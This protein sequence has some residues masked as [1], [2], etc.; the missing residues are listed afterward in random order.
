MSPVRRIVQ[1][2]DLMDRREDIR[3]E[4]HVFCRAIYTLNTYIWAKRFRHQTKKLPFCNLW[5]NRVD[6]PG[7][8]HSGALEYERGERI[9]I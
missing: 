1:P 4:H 3:F 7:H 6:Q 9:D 5:T 2:D 8:I